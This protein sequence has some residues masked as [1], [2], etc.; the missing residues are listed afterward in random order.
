M[1][2]QIFSFSF[3][4]LFSIVLLSLFSCNDED[5]S[6]PPIEPVVSKFTITT[7][8][9]IGG[10][11][12]P[13]QSVDGG[14][15]VTITATAQEHYRLKQWTS[16]CGSF[17]KDNTEIIISAYRNCQIG[18]EFEKINYIIT[19]SSTDGGSVDEGELSREHGQMATFTAEPDQ[20]YQLSGWTPSE[21][22]ACP[23]LLIVN[24]KVTFTVAGKCSL[25]AVFSKTPR[26]ITIEENEN[27]E[28][29]ITPSLKVDH[30]DQVEV[31]ATAHEHYAFKGWSGD[32]GEFGA[33]ESIITITLDSDCTISA[34]FEKVRY[35]ITA[36]ASDG[37]SVEGP[38]E[39]SKV[40]GD[41]VTY[42]ANS[43]EGHDFSG[44]KLTGSGCPSLT[45]PDNAT[46]SFAVGGAC[47]LE[48]VFMKLP[49]TITTSS[50]QGGQI[51]ETQNVEHGDKIS[52]TA[53]ADEFYQLDQWT[54][55]CGTF[56]KEDLTISITVTKNC[57]VEAVFTKVLLAINTSTSEG[58][59]ITQTQ[60]VK[61]GDEVSI[62]ATADE[63]FRLSQWSSD[64][65]AFS[66]EE[67][68]I[69]FTATKDCQVSAEYEK[70]PYSITATASDGGSV[71]ELSF[72]KVQGDSVTLAAEPDEGYTFSQW[73]LTGS[74]CGELSDSSDSSATFVVRGNC[75]LEAI[76][77]KL[78]HVIS[79]SSSVGG[80]IAP[81]QSV[82]VEFGKKITI[83]ATSDVG[84][85]LK[86]WESDC[87]DLSQGQSTI[88]LTPRDDCN[89]KAVFQKKRYTI[90]ASAGTGGIVDSASVESEHGETITINANS[91]EGYEFDRWSL[92]GS[93]CPDYFDS[94]YSI[95]KFEVNGDCALKAIFIGQSD[96]DS[97]IEEETVQETQTRDDDPSN[98]HGNQ[99]QGSDIS[100]VDSKTELSAKEQGELLA[101]EYAGISTTD[102][103][104]LDA[105]G[106]T[107]KLNG[108]CSTAI[109]K[110]LPLEGEDYLIVD[111]DLLISTIQQGG[112]VSKVC[113]TCVTDMQRLIEF[114]AIECKQYDV[115]QAATE[116]TTETGTARVTNEGGES[117]EE[118]YTITHSKQI[119]EKTGEKK[120][121][122]VGSSFNQDIS[123]WDVSN[124]TNMSLMFRYAKEFNQDISNWDVSSVTNMSRMFSIAYSFNQ[125]LS[126]WDVTNVVNC[127]FF[128][129][130]VP[131]IE[132]TDAKQPPFL[133]CKP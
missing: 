130:F 113:T 85:E 37:G 51:T 79:T 32:C 48:A 123:S 45:N 69:S 56:S 72:K 22:S 27:G 121:M 99:G 62:T 11:I 114:A 106:V 133:N 15:S 3:S 112:D 13:S 119:L 9:G 132:F 14:Y 47:H 19:A 108:D 98:V 40:F 36:T 77:S 97:I 103:L 93:G 110:T 115:Y 42:R 91:D 49:R 71:S 5:T 55:D 17:D 53:I 88:T 33:D 60:Q 6:T 117:T 50:S 89:V 65:G 12:T 127:E 59:T 66:K 8:S 78:I 39:Q 70:I 122:C 44:W 28:I 41:V 43:I 111:R 30:G 67:L 73:N 124:V 95:A 25:E 86:G 4:L 126:I 109:G 118:E 75:Q 64:C 23:E 80:K 26:T 104:V 63:H 29:S 34:I 96:L 76:F 131:H 102:N 101:L 18:A 31:T 100:L 7:L 20:G 35:T 84:Y 128:K 10:S 2:F 90:T 38:E 83:T 92:S 57:Q 120:T 21:D 61:H 107:V 87:G 82:E 1:I 16:D 54:S 94:T 58:G 105:N 24:N 52:I 129:G 81:N 116:E 74:A 125:N 68:T 46:A